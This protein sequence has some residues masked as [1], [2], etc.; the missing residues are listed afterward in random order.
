MY[1]NQPTYFRDSNS[2]LTYRCFAFFVCKYSVTLKINFFLEC[3]Q[4]LVW[5]N[6]TC[7]QSCPP[8]YYNS[9]ND[10]NPNAEDMPQSAKCLKCHYSC[11]RC[12]SFMDYQCTECFSDAELYSPSSSENYCY[13]SH[14]MNTVLSEKWYYRVYS[15]TY[16]IVLVLI[17][18]GV[19]LCIVQYAKRRH[20]GYN[21]VGTDDEK[22]PE[23]GYSG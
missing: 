5:Y 16:V 8:T 10:L 1:I 2:L 3:L 7:L 13:S 11:K 9:R 17:L 23:F 21:M 15:I 4:D 20:R 22:I 12:Y 18:S 14:I 6:G 19:V